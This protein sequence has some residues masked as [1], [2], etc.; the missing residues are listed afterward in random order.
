MQHYQEYI[1]NQRLNWWIRFQEKNGQSVTESLASLYTVHVPAKSLQLCSTLCDPMDCSPPG[2][3]VHE[4][5]LARILKLPCLLQGIFPTQRLNPW[6]LHCQAGPLPLAPPGKPL[7]TQME[8]WIP[9]IKFWVKQKRTALL[10]CKAR[11]AT[12]GFHLEN[13]VSQPQRTWWGFL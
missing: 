7:Y 8:N 12:L 2:S 13:Y 4:I 6:L 3:S 1:F 9:E 11:G 10:L 5:F